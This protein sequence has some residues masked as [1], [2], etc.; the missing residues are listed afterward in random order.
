[1]A[2]QLAAGG[3]DLDLCQS[4]LVFEVIDRDLVAQG[5]IDDD[6]IAVC[7]RASRVEERDR[8]AVELQRRGARDRR[9]E[10]DDRFAGAQ[11]DIA[12]IARLEVVLLFVRQEQL[13]P[14]ERHVRLLISWHP[15]F[16]AELGSSLTL[17]GSSPG[18]RTGHPRPDRRCCSPT[19]AL[20]TRS[21]TRTSLSSSS[22]PPVS[23]PRA[24]VAS[25]S[26][27]WRQAGI[28]VQPPAAPPI[29][30]PFRRHSGPGTP[31]PPPGLIWRGGE[32]ARVRPGRLCPEFGRAVSAN[33][34]S[35][36][37]GQSA[38]LRQR[39]CQVIRPA[40]EKTT[41]SGGAATW[42]RRRR[43]FEPEESTWE[44]R[45]GRFVRGFGRAA[46]SPRRLTA[47]KR[48]GRRWDGR[49]RRAGGWC[50]WRGRA[51]PGRGRGPRS[52][53][54]GRACRRARAR[55]RPDGGGCLD[56]DAVGGADD[57]VRAAAQRGLRPRRARGPGLLGN[58]AVVGPDGV[59]DV[60]PPGFANAHALDVAQRL[61]NRNPVGPRRGQSID[62]RRVVVS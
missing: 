57:L 32:S 13:E 59:D 5:L 56:G 16:E 2:R 9:A 17:P 47:A 34:G 8:G 40:P 39:L 1:M 49:G 55:N 50:R 48:C 41:W 15:A 29:S 10:G 3:A 52:P 43:S 38:K 53:S 45:H 21:P 51:E 62:R 44:G 28:A 60:G 27:E 26:R 54:R 4:H 7:G 36:L 33:S 11:V 46:E 24:R 20:R 25:N 19:R 23:K 31:S 14:L 12:G 6:A 42:E 22:G 58:E 61:A 35:C 30:A 37:K 18:I